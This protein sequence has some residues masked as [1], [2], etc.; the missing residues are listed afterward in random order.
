V[1][2][3]A[4]PRL[5]RVSNVACPI[6][7][8]AFDTEPPV[9]PTSSRSSH[10]LWFAVLV[11][12]VIASL[13]AGLGLRSPTPPDEPRFVL[14]A[15]H[16]VET[17]QWLLPHRGSE[18]YAEK[19]ATFMWIQA[20]TYKMI[21]NWNLSFLLPSL[22]AALLTLWLTWDMSRRLWNRQVARYAVVALFVCIQ[23][24]LMAKR[25]QIDMVLVGMTTV[26]LWGLVRH[27][28]LGPNWWALA[29]AAFAAGAGTVTKGV[30]FLPL[31][32]LLPWML[33]RWRHPQAAGPGRSWRW[34]LLLPAFLAGTAI[35]LG[36][37]AIALLQN[38]DP[39]LQAYA[40]E[41]L[42]KQTGTRYANAWHHHQPFWYYL[43][44]MAT[45]WL[46]GS[47][48]APW[49]VPAWWRRC[50]RADPRYILLLGWALLVLLFFSASPGKR[51]V[52]ILPML[53]A[54]AVAAAPLLP[55]LLRRT[56]VRWL[57]LIYVLLLATATL[58]VGY[59]AVHGDGWA[60]RNAIK[61]AIDP[62][63]LPQVG[64][65]LI[66]FGAA[67]LVVA[68]MLRLRRAGLAVVLTTVMLWAMYGLGAM[69]ALDPYSSASL[70]MDK[71][72]ARIGPDAELGMVAWRE[73]NL[74]QTHPQ[75]TDFGF[76]R[77]VAEQ[78]EAAA[79]W[80]AQ[81]PQRRWLFVLDKAMS[82]CAEPSQVIDIGSANR[83]NWQLLPGTALHADCVASTHG[84]VTGG[85]EA[86]DSDGD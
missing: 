64:W 42:F 57:L 79:R 56:G 3:A 4:E 69:P 33:W 30:G 22:L 80:V 85:D 62:W 46:P 77:P 38:P 10:T 78:W 12:L 52:Y 61:R 76:K 31:L 54:L 72:R 59:G 11:A 53:P 36:P 68:L 6:I 24:G 81:D 86:L 25:A 39:H 44:V 66:G 17:G 19:P 41:L 50:R 23:F 71:V 51:E 29:L 37:L 8:P 60:Q 75:A 5:R 73:Q 55:G 20:A 58:V 16:M 49:L 82:P 35:W 47:L 2:E 27:L 67:T 84:V 48:L 32:M 63:V 65:W 7:L 14:A 26:A 83:N 13:L 28:L 74:L 9:R 18:L 70:V 34:W 45:L 40:K 43:Q 21:G 15:R 1:V